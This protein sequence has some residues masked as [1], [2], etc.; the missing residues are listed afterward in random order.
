MP[1]KVLADLS[2]G[3]CEG[4]HAT[5]RAAAAHHPLPGRRSRFRACIGPS[6]SSGLEIPI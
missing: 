2:R 5:E 6:R 1:D 3:L 4:E